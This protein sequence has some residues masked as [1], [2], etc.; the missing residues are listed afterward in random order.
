MFPVLSIHLQDTHHLGTRTCGIRL[1]HSGPHQNKVT[2]DFFFIYPSTRLPGCLSP[3]R[4]AG[5]TPAASL[6]ATAR[7]GNYNSMLLSPSSI[8]FICDGKSNV[9]TQVLD[10]SVLDVSRQVVLN[11]DAPRLQVVQKDGHYFTLNNAQ[12]QL[13]RHLEK[14]GM[15]SRVKVEVVPLT[16]VPEDVRRMMVIPSA[17]APSAEEEGQNTGK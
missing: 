15:C 10:K 4:V 6:L 14:D 3:K 11:G 16:D 5:S 13:C 8:Y 12:L 2:D 9:L 7:L 17:K 1:S